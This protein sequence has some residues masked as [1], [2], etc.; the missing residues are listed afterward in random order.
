MAMVMVM[1]VMVMMVMAAAMQG[2]RGLVTGGVMPVME[3]L[4]ARLRRLR[5]TA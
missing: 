1:M 4:E 2:Q 5:L 3:R